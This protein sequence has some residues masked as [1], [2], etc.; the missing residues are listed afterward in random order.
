[1]SRIIV[2]TADQFTSKVA[3]FRVAFWR[4]FRCF[5]TC[6]Q[7]FQH[8][9][10]TVCSLSSWNGELTWAAN[11]ICE[12]CES[13]NLVLSI[14][15]VHQRL[16]IVLWR[17]RTLLLRCGGSSC[18]DRG[19]HTALETNG[20]KQKTVKTGENP[21]SGGA[22]FDVNCSAVQTKYGTFR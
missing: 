18:R 6:L 20:N 4:S 22:P 10:R 7:W 16:D 15:D 13:T 12:V 9:L 2:W 1:M 3:P 8:H 17:R 14:L 19:A 5:F 21:T 11:A